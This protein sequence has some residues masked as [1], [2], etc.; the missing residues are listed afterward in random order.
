MSACPTTMVVWKEIIS[1]AKIVLVFV[2][3]DVKINQKYDEEHILETA[4]PWASKC[5]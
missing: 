1:N 2:K 4:K 3:T 5:A